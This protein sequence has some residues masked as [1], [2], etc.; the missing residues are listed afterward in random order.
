MYIESLYRNWPLL[1]SPSFLPLFVTSHGSLPRAHSPLY[2]WR[3]LVKFR[4]LW[5]SPQDGLL[6]HICE[7]FLRADLYQIDHL[8]IHDPLTYLVI[9]HINVLRPLMI[10]VILI[11]MNSILTIAMN[12]NWILY[13]TESLNQSSQPQRF[14]WCLNSSHILYSVIERATVS[15]NS[16]F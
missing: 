15:C 7:I 16:V 5:T 14:L 13:D 3:T 9:P 12:P 4:V 11:K 2:L 1:H 6:Y 10:H 8:T